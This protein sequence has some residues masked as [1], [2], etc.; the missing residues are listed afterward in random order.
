MTSFSCRRAGYRHLRIVRWPACRPGAGSK[1]NYPDLSRA[2]META[3]GRADF[4]MT[5]GSFRYIDEVRNRKALVLKDGVLCDAEG[6]R[7]GWMAVES[8]KGV[9][10]SGAVQKE[11]ILRF[12][13]DDPSLNRFYLT[14]PADPDEHC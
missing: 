8:C 11:E 13:L 10:S 12:H 7:A 3:E 5:K 1:M 6:R 14:F 4:P 2:V 9:E